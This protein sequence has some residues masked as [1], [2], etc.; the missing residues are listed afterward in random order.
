MVHSQDSIVSLIVGMS[1]NRVIGVENRLPWNIPE[2]LKRFREITTGHP[3]VMGRKT[4]ESIGRALP[5]RTNIVVT[6]DVASV[7]NRVPSGVL[8]AASLLEALKAAQGADIP[9]GEE[10][11]VIGGGEIYKQSLPLAQKLYITQIDQDYLGDAF[12]PAFEAAD[13]REIS[14]ET[15]ESREGVPA[16]EFIVLDRIV[17]SNG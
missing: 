14:R 11:F 7:Q 10:I 16:F 5:K 12:F 2:D 6:R 4:F 3:I 13:F 17:R 1:R 9:G 15:H 8:V